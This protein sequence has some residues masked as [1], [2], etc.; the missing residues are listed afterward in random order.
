[1]NDDSGFSI[2]DLADEMAEIA[3]ATTDPETARRLMQLVVR[4]LE[5]AGL[6]PEDDEGGGESPSCWISDLA[7][8]PA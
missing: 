7:D 5:Q 6:P 4:L 2:T 1:M 3:R 8:C